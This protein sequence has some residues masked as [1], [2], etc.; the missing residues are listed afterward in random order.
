MHNRQVFQQMMQSLYQR[1]S[2]NRVRHM[3]QQQDPLPEYPEDDGPLTNSQIEQ[4]KQSAKTK[5]V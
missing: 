1:S 4:L 2:R 5:H 3:M